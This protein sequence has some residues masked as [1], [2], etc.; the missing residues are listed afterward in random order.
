MSPDE[1]F[2]GWMKDMVSI[3]NDIIELFSLRRTFRDVAEV[4]Q[5]NRRL[6]EVGGHLWGWMVR[7]YASSVLIRV[8]RQVQGQKG[9]VDFDQLLNA[10]IKRPDALVRGRRWP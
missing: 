5:N 2:D 3:K 10:I 7:N 1:I 6:Q 4:V 9:T 8:R